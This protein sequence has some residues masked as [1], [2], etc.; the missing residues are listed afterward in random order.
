MEWLFTFLEQVAVFTFIFTKEDNFPVSAWRDSDY[1]K[2]FTTSDA[3]KW[4][5][6][7]K[8]AIKNILDIFKYKVNIWLQL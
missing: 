5:R 7:E 4:E 2:T 8:R 6:F 1:K 3:T